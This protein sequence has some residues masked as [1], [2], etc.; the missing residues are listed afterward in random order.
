[1]CAAGDAEVI[2][3]RGDAHFPEENIG[4]IGIV[5]L[6]GVDKD[7]PMLAAQ[8]AGTGRSFDKLRPGPDNGYDFH[9]RTSILLRSATPFMAFFVSNTNR[10][11]FCTKA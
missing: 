11:F 7:L 1:M 6:P 9:Q 8:S 4:H 2:V 5:M 3:R 10:A